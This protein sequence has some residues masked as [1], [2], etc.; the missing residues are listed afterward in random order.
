MQVLFL[1]LLLMTLFDGQF[2]GK[3]FEV[4]LAAS[5]V[6]LTLCLVQIRYLLHLN[7]IVLI[8]V[9]AWAWW[10]L[11]IQFD[12]D[13]LSFA[14]VGSPASTLS[15]WFGQ[16]IGGLIM[17]RSKWLREELMLLVVTLLLICVQILT[18]LFSSV[19]LWPNRRVRDVLVCT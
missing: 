13:T 14:F 3:T 18:I 1:F 19:I 16:L 4:E 15:L 8:G 5:L 11:A 9:L 7:R 12:F 17:T 10:T 2:L 6:L